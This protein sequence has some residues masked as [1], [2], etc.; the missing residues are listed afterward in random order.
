MTKK[1]TRTKL[2]EQQ[3]AFVVQRLACWDSPKEV[4]EALM[5]EHGVKLAP[6]NIEA[7]DPNKRAGRNLAKKWRELFES[8]RKVFLN[9][10]HTHVPEANKAVRI[11]QLA[12][13]ARA[14]KGR[15]N[16]LGMADMLER[17][18][19]ELGNVHSNARVIKGDKDHPLA[20]EYSD[21]TPDQV[22][23]LLA[24]RLSKLGVTV[25]E[26]GLTELSQPETEDT[27]H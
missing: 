15:G 2:T 26:L 18:A 8:S 10:I 21:I 20:V 22:D 4:S 16:Y 25:A 7:Y 17:I 24:D 14:F 19:K 9:D 6:Q 11:R 13:A 27:R 12:H 5:E 23:R 1:S 3:K